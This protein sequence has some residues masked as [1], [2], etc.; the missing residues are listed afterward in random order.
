MTRDLEQIQEGEA[1]DG[2]TRK[3]ATLL[4][5]ALATVGLVFA[6]G[7]FLGQRADADTQHASDP[8]AAL[9]EQALLG[10]STD[11]DD[12]ADAPIDVPREELAFP[13]VLDTRPEVE[14]A[15]VAAAAELAHPDPV[16]ASAGGAP[17]RLPFRDAFRDDSRLPTSLPAAVA[18]GPGSTSLARTRQLDPLVSAALPP[19]PERTPARAGHDGRYT[20]QVIS[21]EDSLEAD[22]FSAELRARGHQAFVVSAEIP[23]RGHFY[24]VRIGPFESMREAESYRASFEAEERM[25]SYVVRRRDGDQG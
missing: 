9:E 20:L 1:G 18:A 7:I 23:G 21:Y 16:P 22:T 8:L 11:E 5:A 3:V 13:E 15:I 14:A 19:E 10:G 12:P 2:S 4:M 17:P 25:N 6:M 24:R